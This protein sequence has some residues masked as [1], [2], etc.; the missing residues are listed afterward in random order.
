MCVFHTSNRHLVIKVTGFKNATVCS[1]SMQFWWGFVWL[2]KI[3]Y[4]CVQYY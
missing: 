3:K 4:D 2:F 1:E